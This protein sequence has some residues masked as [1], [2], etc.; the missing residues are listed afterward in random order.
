MSKVFNALPCWG[1]YTAAY[2]IIQG[3]KS[4]ALGNS[5]FMLPGTGPFVIL[6]IEETFGPLA[7]LILSI[8]ELF[9]FFQ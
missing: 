1:I 5:N 2:R 6:N 4:R 8:P 9:F 7:G 3:E